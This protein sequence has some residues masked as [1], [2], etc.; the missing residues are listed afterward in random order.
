MT[1]NQ[2][3][4]GDNSVVDFTTKETI[5]EIKLKLAYRYSRSR[6]DPKFRFPE[7][8]ED[9]SAGFVY[10]INRSELKVYFSK[11]LN[12]KVR[13]SFQTA[14]P[15]FSG[16]IIDRGDSRIIKGQIGLPEWT[17][18]LTL[19][20]FAFFGF[21]YF[22]SLS[23]ADIEGPITIPLYFI[24]FGLVS[25]LIGLIRT[26]KKVNEMVDELQRVFSNAR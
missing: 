11:D 7:E 19:L 14:Y 22:V 4:L 10:T 8:H 15:W 16:N 3:F 17:Y 18:Y 2:L 1:L 26:R 9:Y 5:D 23:S 6:L 13:H 21:I 12:R 25:T 20:W 24:I